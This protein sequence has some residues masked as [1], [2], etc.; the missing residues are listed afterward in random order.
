[1]L[2]LAGHGVVS[3]GIYAYPTAEA[4]TLN[5]SDPAVRLES[6]VSDAEFVEWAKKVPALHQVMILDTCA[7]GGIEGRLAEKRGVPGDQIRAIER[8]KDRTGF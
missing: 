8:L 4:R 7:A 5:L 3:Q 6:A 2:Y 1:M